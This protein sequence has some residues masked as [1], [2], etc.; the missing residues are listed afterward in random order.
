MRMPRN[1]ERAVRLVAKRLGMT[2]ADFLESLVGKAVEL[3]KFEETIGNSSEDAQFSAVLSFAMS[4]GH[5]IAMLDDIEKV[6][7]LELSPVCRVCRHNRGRSCPAYST[8]PDDIW[9]AA[10]RHDEVRLDQ[11]GVTV[12]EPL[13][14]E[15]ARKL[16]KVL[17]PA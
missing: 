17:V 6:K 8:I 13:D 4:L 11:E 15:H 5:S 12:F 7:S 3:R 16:A 9:S 2:S 14:N 10:S 1:L